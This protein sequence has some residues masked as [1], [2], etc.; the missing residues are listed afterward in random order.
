MIDMHLKYDNMHTSGTFNTLIC[1]NYH[2]NLCI[3]CMLSI[4]FQGLMDFEIVLT[5]H[6]YTCQFDF[7]QRKVGGDNM[8]IKNKNTLLIMQINA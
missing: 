4:I 3:N 1:I 7:F 6:F 2:V 8:I 5:S